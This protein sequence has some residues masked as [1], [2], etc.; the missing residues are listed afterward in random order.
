M[1]LGKAAFVTAVLAGASRSTNAGRITLAL[2]AIF[3]PRVLIRELRDRDR[4]AGMHEAN[5]RQRIP[6][7]LVMVPNEAEP[8]LI[9]FRG[10]IA[11]STDRG[12][13]SSTRDPPPPSKCSDAAC[14]ES[15][16]HKDSPRLPAE[17]KAGDRSTTSSPP[18]AASATR[19]SRFR[20][21]SSS[22]RRR[23]TAT[24]SLRILEFPSRTGLG[25]SDR[26]GSWPSLPSRRRVRRRRFG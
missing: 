19:C 6:G 11:P 15:P 4:R 12:C 17:S 22:R 3:E 1:H 9:V 8:G 23:G 13:S 16:S 21:P 2:G 10:S 5:A 26:R 25:S 18:A 14:S 24:D 20:G 7:P